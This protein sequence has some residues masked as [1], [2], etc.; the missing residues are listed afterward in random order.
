MCIR[1]REE[2]GLPKGTDLF[3]NVKSHAETE[4]GAQRILAEQGEDG[5]LRSVMLADKLTPESVRV[6]QIL[7]RRLDDQGRQVE[8]DALASMS[9]SYT[10]LRAHETGRN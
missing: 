8:A 2:A 10:H 9:V 6:A 7:V 4:A 3:Y 1:D 5:A